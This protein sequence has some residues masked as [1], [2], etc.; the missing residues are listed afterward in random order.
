MKVFFALLSGL[1]FGL[2]LIVSGMVRPDVVLGFLD[3]L[4][5]WDPS[6]AL[7]MIGALAVAFP[8][9]ALARRAGQEGACAPSARLDGRLVLG[10]ALFGVGW[11][12]AGYCPGP[13]LASLAA[14][15]MPALVILAGMLAGMGFW[16]LIER[17][18]RAK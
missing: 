3:P 10:A 4:G 12:M 9:F 16:P 13:A 17:R 5:R 1:L 6:L 14:G 15:Q 18:I 11:G 8:G 2:G 7:V